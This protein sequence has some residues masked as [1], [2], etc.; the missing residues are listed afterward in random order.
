MEV[1]YR[2]E[3]DVALKRNT[4]FVKK[5]NRHNDVFNGKRE[6]VVYENT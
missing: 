2:N 6:S 4:A 3:T 1:M 5:Y